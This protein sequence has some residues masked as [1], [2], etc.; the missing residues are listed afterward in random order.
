MKKF[1]S[2]MLVILASLSLLACSK[3]YS[4]RDVD[5]PSNLPSISEDYVAIHYQRSDNEYSTWGLW[6]WSND[7]VD[8]NVVDMFNYQDDFGVIAFYPLSKWDLT[9]G[10]LGIIIRKVDSW[11]KDGTDSDRFIK[12]SDYEKDSKGIYHVYFFNDDEN[13]YVNESKTKVDKIK[14]AQFFDESQVL[15]VSSAPLDKVELYCDGVKIS[16][17]NGAGRAMVTVKIPD[18]H[19]ISFT[20]EYT[21]K[22]TF[23]ETGAILESK[24]ALNGLY[25]TDLFNNQYY[26]N[27]DLG[28]IYSKTET[29]FK[30]WSPFSTDIKLRI[31]ENGTPKSVD[32][33]KGNDQYTEYSMTKGAKGVWNYKLSGDQEGKFYTYYVTNSSYP[34]GKEI[35]DPYAKS[36]GVNGIRGMVV[37]FSKTNPDGWDDISYLSID[38]T[39]LTVYETHVADVTSSKTWGGTKAYSKKFLGLVEE[40]TTYTENGVTVSTGFDHIKELGV[41]AIQLIPIFDQANNEINTQFN[42]G[43]NPLN[44]NV[45]EGCYSTNPYDGYTKIKEFKQLV[46]ACNKNGITTIMDVVYNHV[47]GAVGS[48]FDVLVPNYYYRYSNGVLSNGSGCG[49]ELASENQMV[50]KF[51]KDS[52]AFW[53]SEYKLGGFRFDLMGLEDITTMNEVVE[54]LN[55]VNPNIVVYGEPWTGGSSTLP[56]A[57]QAI[58]SNANKFIGFG[59][60]NDQMRDALIKGGLSGEKE[61]GWITNDT[62]IASTDVAKIVKGINGETANAT[63][64]PN[65]T[66][67]YVTCHDNYTLYDRIEAA[68]ITDDS[69]IKKMAQLA[70]SVVLTSKGTTFILAGEEFLRTKNGNSNSYN[71]SYKINELDYSLKIENKTIFD[72][73]KSLI[74]FK[75]NT[76]ALHG[77]DV[78]ISVTQKDGGSVLVYTFQSNNK[79][80][81]IIHSNGV[82]T[83]S[84]ID[85]TGY[86]LVLDT[87]GLITEIG[88]SITPEKYQTIIL[89][90]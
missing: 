57:E 72:N 56:Q 67:N 4:D 49:N 83:K 51:I 33:T 62:N 68:G 27:G 85:T 58:Q 76:D 35:C 31:Y 50:R 88:E 13:I 7:S 53:A 90:K 69:T 80:Y 24:I 60:F 64:D 3:S 10:E 45:V 11:T 34:N 9:S 65:K 87:L 42:W 37:D 20:K 23:R 40:G 63:N 61:K 30:V 28:A 70:N 74:E 6:L 38:R 36:S 59:Q 75:Q 32:N 82:G 78:E 81:M 1:L 46:M 25:N 41:N 89:E 39:A 8:D 66:V 79:E 29:T 26:Y 77:N 73:Y 2:I 5:Y 55:T 43:Y 84:A 47:N 52:T 71:A 16:E 86:S 18:N 44:Y 12:F 54:N 14:S 22:A 21:A 48:N 19:E 17:E 15:V